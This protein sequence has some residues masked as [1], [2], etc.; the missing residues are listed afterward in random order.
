[1]TALVFRVELF[2]CERRGTIG[3]ITANDG[4]PTLLRNASVCAPREAATEVVEEGCEIPVR[5]Y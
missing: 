2:A 3:N 4:A 1:M 5:D